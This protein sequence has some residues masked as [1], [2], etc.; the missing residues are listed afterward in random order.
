MTYG[1]L[2]KELDE[3]L[4][5]G[6]IDK[7]SMPEKDKVVL[8]IRARGENNYLLISAGFAPRIHLTCAK[9]ENLPVAPS[10]CMHLRKNIGGG[11]ISGVE[12]VPFERVIVINILF[13]NELGERENKKLI[14]EI[15]G[16]YSNIILV[17]ENGKISDAIRHISPDI[18]EKRPV[19][20][21]IA[22]SVP[23]QDKLAPTDGEGIIKLNLSDNPLST[24]QKSLKGIAPIS[25]A[26]AVFRAEKSDD[27]RAAVADELAQMY[28]RPTNPCI[29][30]SENS[31]D[32]FIRPYDSVEGEYSYYPTLNE[33]MD[34][35]FRAKDKAAALGERGRG[36]TQTV[37]HALKRADKRAAEFYVRLNSCGDAETQKLYG[38]LITANLYR[39]KKGDKTLCAENYYT[40][41]TV[42]IALDE[43][44]NPSQNA[45][46]YYKKYNKKKKTLVMTEE[47]LNKTLEEKE[48][49][50]ELLY[51]LE[52]VAEQSEFDD[53]YEE[54]SALGLIKRR[55]EKTRSKPSQPRKFEADGFT[56]LIGRNN[57]QNDKLVK[58]AERNDIWLH[59]KGFH[60]SHVLIKTENRTVPEK[61]LLAAAAA[62]AYY[63]E[64]SESDK[65]DVDYTLARYVQKPVGSPPGKVIYTHQTTLTVRPQPEKTN[66]D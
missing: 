42:N 40:G 63:S 13:R 29:C 3:K 45:A 33:A 66:K 37:K 48:I 10:F 20:P 39:I 62:A 14:C 54:M 5:D 43:N 60:G 24:L 31:E 44:L 50:K 34:A 21:G 4:R 17:R 58:S 26:E 52:N 23:F 56:V 38:E 64:A 12:A 35:F 57:L 27:F 15:M 46:A 9:S 25:V 28:T 7:V 30:R 11:V 6:R 2:V 49:L 55:R 59:V 1:F 18:S 51:E 47:Q 41:E 8:T 36:L 16:K 22:Y 19:L 32:Y 53:I 65:A 61:V